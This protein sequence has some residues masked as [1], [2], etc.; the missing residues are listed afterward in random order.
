M[1]KTGQDFID[2]KE[3]TRILDIKRATLYAYVSRGLIRSYAKDG[4]KAKFYNRQDIERLAVRTSARSGHGAVAAGALRWGEPVLDS[5]I[6]RIGKDGPS[7]RGYTAVSLADRDIPFEN[8]CELLWSGLLPDSQVLWPSYKYAPHPDILK[9]SPVRTLD[10]NS[11][12]P[13]ML[14]YLINDYA[15]QNHDPQIDLSHNLTVHIR[16]L[17]QIA[18]A[19]LYLL[20]KSAKHDSFSEP[21]SLAER[22]A[23]ALMSRP[24]QTAIQLINMGLILSADHELTPSTFAARVAAST[25]ADLF[26]CLSSATGALAGPRHGGV[27]HTLEQVKQD[28]MTTPIETYLRKMKKN[29]ENLPGFAHS[30]YSNSDPRA[31]SLMHLT[32]LQD[33]QK[34]EYLRWNEFI[35]HATKTGWGHPSIDTALILMSSGLGLPTG[36]AGAIFAIGRMAGWMA[37]II[38]QRLSGFMVRPRARYVGR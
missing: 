35:S 9:S 30:L 31:D 24:S 12:V 4:E 26:S 2:A 32:K 1:P 17:M 33:Y 37:H 6:T 15:L 5:S 25:G 8:V 29:G 27:F 20:R 11:F 28:V 21:C 3:A 22:I 34:E 19:H 18:G 38:E 36:S 13:K 14:A 7:Y 23:N 16:N 10:P